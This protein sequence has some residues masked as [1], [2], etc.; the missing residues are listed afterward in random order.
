[1]NAVSRLRYVGVGSLLLLSLFTP[2]GAA[3]GSAIAIPVSAAGTEDVCTDLTLW[4]QSFKGRLPNTLEELSQLT[5]RQRKHVFNQLPPQVK[6]RLWREHLSGFLSSQRGLSRE[7][8][9]FVKRNIDSI[10]PELYLGAGRFKSAHEAWAHDEHHRLMRQE[11]ERLFGRALLPVFYELGWTPNKAEIVK[12]GF[13]VPKADCECAT[14]DNWC[15]TL[16]VKGGCVPTS[17]G[18]G[19]LECKPCDGHCYW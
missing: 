7:Q 2:A 16:C 10:T 13:D 6:A 18:C 14:N 15:P 11:G 4:M 8:I 19:W 17:T 1:M 3:P 12:A 9:E 5:R